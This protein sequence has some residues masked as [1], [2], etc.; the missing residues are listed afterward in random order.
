MCCPIKEK[1]RK[2]YTSLFST[3]FYVSQTDIYPLSDTCPVRKKFLM[4]FIHNNNL[5]RLFCISDNRLMANYISLKEAAKYCPYSQD[6]LKLRARQGKLKA[7]KMGRNWFTTR[8]WLEE[9]KRGSTS[10]LG[11][12]GLTS[13]ARGQTSKKDWLTL[14]LITFL[15]IA[16]V[17]L[18]LSFFEPVLE[19]FI[20]AKTIEISP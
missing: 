1:V 14:F 11:K 6:Y 7:V 15:I 4:G 2:K 9:Y 3:I 19:K 12:R 17:F 8:E 20:P 13:T 10:T 5:D 18:L 16:G